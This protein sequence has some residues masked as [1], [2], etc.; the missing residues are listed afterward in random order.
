MKTLDFAAQAAQT[1]LRGENG[2]SWV[3]HHVM[4][5]AD[6]LKFDGFLVQHKHPLA[7]EAGTC[8]NRFR[9]FVQRMVDLENQ[10]RKSN[11]MV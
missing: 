5:S 2:I 6:R 8:E 1:E 10:K 4:D 7:Y 11:E 9:R 3:F